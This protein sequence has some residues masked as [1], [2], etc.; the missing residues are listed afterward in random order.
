MYS[1]GN[2]RISFVEGSD[3]PTFAITAACTAVLH[4]LGTYRGPQVDRGVAYIEKFIPPGQGK[5]P[6]YYYAHYYAAQVMHM[7]PGGRGRR[8]LEA[9]RA[10]LARRQ[11]PDGRWA[12]DPEDTLASG[13]S[14]VLN[15]AWALQIALIDRGALPL[16]ER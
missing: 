16:H 7:L 14:E 1:I 10:E 15:T 12:A 2:P 11:R 3:Q 6:F 13:D 5:A 9:V 4:A 8:W